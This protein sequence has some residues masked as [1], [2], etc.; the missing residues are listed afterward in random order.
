[1][2]GQAKGRGIVT[3]FVIGVCEPLVPD[4]GFRIMTEL[5]DNRLLM[6]KKVVIYY[7]KTLNCKSQTSYL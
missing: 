5:D 3:D 1:M 7:Y 6:S 2:I 4:R